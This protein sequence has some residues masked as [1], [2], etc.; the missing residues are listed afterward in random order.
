M[1]PTDGLPTPQS[2]SRQDGRTP[3]DAS[4]SQSWRLSLFWRTFFQIGLLLLVSLVIWLQALRVTEVEP[5]AMQTAQQLTTLVNLS[6]AALVHSDAIARVS[7]IK[8]MT[9]LEGV[10]I[11]PREPD[12]KFD[13][14]GTDALSQRIEQEMKSLLGNDTVVANSVNDETGL[15][16]GFTIEGDNYWLQT[17]RARFDRPGGRTWMIW[18]SGAMVLSLLGAALIARRINAPLRK[19]ALATARVHD[20]DFGAAQLDPHVGTT[21]IR[22][23]NIGFNQMTRKLAEIQQ[24]RA[25]MLA[26]I[27]HDLRTPL[28]RLRL[29]TELSVPDAQA[30]EHMAS[31]IEQLDAIVDKFMDY[32]RAVHVR[33]AAV[34]LR[35]LVETCRYAVKDHGDLEIAIDIDEHLAVLADEVELGR[36]ISNLLENARRYGRSADGV[37]R[38]EI[39]A[40]TRDDWIKVL[41]RDHGSGVPH[42]Q[43]PQLTQPFFRGNTARTAAN[44]SGLGL[45]IVEK[46]IH[47]MGGLFALVNAEGGGLAAHIKLQRAP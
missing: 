19:L 9:D 37:A 21:E 4:P 15:W 26:G 2:A 42:E 22:E 34:P 35:A 38:V 44:G 46:N 1:A 14:F 33:M 25:V 45:S 18:L 12:D 16:I 17:D 41:V 6:R 3:S 30:R 29:E 40:R 23:V 5:R 47:R 7:L 32:A 27:S 20:G 13:L 31:D 24:E 43:L 39:S 36:V 8:S 28:A 11:V 10:R